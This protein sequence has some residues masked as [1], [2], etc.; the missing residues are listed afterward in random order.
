MRAPGSDLLLQAWEAGLDQ[1]PARRAVSL[2]ACACA[3]SDDDL[4]RLPVGVRDA[5][6]LRLRRALFGEA[7]AA[8]AQCPACGERLDVSFGVDDVCPGSLAEPDAGEAPGSYQLRSGAYQVS[9]RLPNSADL[10]S[11]TLDAAA[12]A[13]L[14]R[15]CVSAATCDGTLV[16][17]DQLPPD[18]VSAISAAMAA[19]DPLARIELALICPGCGH[20]WENL[21]DIGDFLWKE[22]DAWARRTLQDV[23]TLARAYGWSEP[24]VLAMT[25][26]RRDIYLDM[27]RL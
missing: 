6:L 2:L 16:A 23:H 25:P 12:P 27:V 15:R 14:L 3:D 26:R 19:A 22:V 4:A 17:A 5:R 21:L 24:E 8:L 10:G 11:V 7:V 18:V 9:Y 13:R 1:A 20:G